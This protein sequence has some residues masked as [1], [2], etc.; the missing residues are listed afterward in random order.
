M[1]SIPSQSRLT[2]RSERHKLLSAIT[3]VTIISIHSIILPSLYNNLL[4][5]M[6]TSQLSGQ[7]Y[8]YEVL[9]CDNTRR[10]QEVFRMKAEVF[11]FLCSELQ[12]KGEL[13]PSRHIAV[14][15]KVGMFLWTVARAASNRDVQERFQ[16][17]GDTVS[18]H[19]HQV[20]HAVNLLIPDYI[21]LP[22]TSETCVSI[23]STP[24]FYTY[25][26]DCIGALDGTH[27]AAKVPNED[28]A[29]YRNRKGWLSQNV[30]ACC[31]FDNSLFTYILAD[32]E[33]SA[34]DGAVLE[35]AFDAGFK[36]PMGKY[37]LADAGY[38]FTPWC[39]TPYRGVRYHL[40]E[41]DKANLR[42][43]FL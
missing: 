21:K 15:E 38:A 33:G 12:S 5:P 14:D 41:W 23:T 10:C 32:W 26:N 34:H 40:R 18:R 13:H 42:Y 30:L 4:Q 24:K 39:I 20:L 31:E 22:S 19:F 8:M 2:K 1:P 6:R 7:E 37:Y 9:N 28:T 36:V 3:A 43:Q 27:I 11:R 16:H 29:A 25:F 17:S 35:A